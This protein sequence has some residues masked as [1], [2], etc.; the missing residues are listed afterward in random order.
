MV[1]EFCNLRAQTVML[2]GSFLLLTTQP[3]L[4]TA[5]DFTTLRKSSPPH[6]EG[7]ICAGVCLRHHHNTHLLSTVGEFV[8]AF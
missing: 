6:T 1:R 5:Y 7:I 4:P 2:S 3:A 8:F